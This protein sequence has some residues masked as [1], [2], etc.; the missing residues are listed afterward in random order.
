MNRIWIKLYLEILDD[1]KMGRLPDRLWRRCVELFLMAG[2]H[3][4]DGLLPAPEE[5]AWTLRL[6]AETV[7][8]DMH[9]LET[10][11]IV[12]PSP[13]GWVV[14]NFEKRQY[15]ESYER[16]KRYRNAKSNGESNEGEAVRS[17]SS[18]TSNSLSNSEE[19]EGTGEG[20]IWIPD[21]VREAKQHPDIQLFEKV[22]GWFPGSNQYK[23]IVETFDYLRE[24]HGPDLTDY[25]KPYWL[26]WSTR[27]TAQGKPYSKNSAVWYSEWAVS[28]NVPNAN[29][30]EPHSGE[31]Q[32]DKQ[33]IIRKV[34]QNAKR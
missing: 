3:G 8:K 17:S 15:S 31:T 21:T 20:T 12:R 1:P 10:F 13:N 9:E 16:V 6:N 28:G 22:T 4:N 2:K 18:S 23:T 29:G 19:G 27:K 14:V 26:A 7:T 34:A 11:G 32:A 30:H 25:L 24:K 33:A 5:M